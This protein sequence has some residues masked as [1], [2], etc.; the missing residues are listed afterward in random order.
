M[1]FRSYIYFLK[2]QYG[3]NLDGEENTARDMIK[4]YITL[5][6]LMQQNQEVPKEKILYAGN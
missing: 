6:N 5:L 1:L 3:K 4:N 2:Q